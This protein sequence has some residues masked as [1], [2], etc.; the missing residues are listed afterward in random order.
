[1]TG[2]HLS[3]KLMKPYIILLASTLLF[4]P[5]LSCADNSPNTTVRS[6][7]L[8]SGNILTIST[9]NG[10]SVASYFSTKPAKKEILAKRIIHILKSVKASQSIIDFAE[11]RLHRNRRL[12]KEKFK[13]SLTDDDGTV[14]KFTY[15]SNIRSALFILNYQYVG[16][17]KI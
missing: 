3:F 11:S 15:N 1:M 5:L 10:K 4:L 17:S 16:P 6:V 2:Y 8:S 9:I 7:L 13:L 14:Y 12:K